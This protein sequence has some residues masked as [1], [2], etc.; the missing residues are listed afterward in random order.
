MIYKGIVESV[1]GKKVRVRIPKLNKSS[2]AVGATSVGQLS[3][4][5]I[6]TLPGISVNL[7]VNDIV[8]VEF[9][10]TINETPV[11][12]GTLYGFSTTSRCNLEVAELLV[13]V[14]TKLPKETEIGDIKYSHLNKLTGITYNIQSKFDDLIRITQSQEQQIKT[15]EERIQKLENK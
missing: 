15:L 6:C 2:F 1:S 10:D 5:C 11:I 9:D 12:V 4:A 7:Q 3:D 13:N 8:F 14:L